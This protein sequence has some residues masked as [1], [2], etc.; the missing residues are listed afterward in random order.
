MSRFIILN[1]LTDAKAIKAFDIEGY[2]FNEG[3]STATD[4]VFTRGD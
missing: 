1:R 3:L 4:W 2:A